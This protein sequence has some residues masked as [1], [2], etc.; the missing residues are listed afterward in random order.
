VVL[1]QGCQVWQVGQCPTEVVVL[2]PGL[3]PSECVATQARQVRRKVGGGQLQVVQARG[4]VG[5]RRKCC[6][7]GSCS[8][9]MLILPFLYSRQS[10]SRCERRCLS[11]SRVSRRGC[12]A[13]EGSVRVCAPACEGLP[14]LLQVVGRACG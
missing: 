6:A 9:Y 3:L 1:G 11:Q 13:G 2:M 12:I 7:R 10:Q 5:C 14:A 4:V 8:W